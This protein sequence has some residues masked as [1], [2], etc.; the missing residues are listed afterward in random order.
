MV[1][2]MVMLLFIFISTSI[3][4]HAVKASYVKVCMYIYTSIYRW[5][6][7]HSLPHGM[8][9]CFT[10]ANDDDDLQKGAEYDLVFYS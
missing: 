6:K 4:G 7:L 2:Q 9:P 1:M 5:S 10:Y 3:K 8:T